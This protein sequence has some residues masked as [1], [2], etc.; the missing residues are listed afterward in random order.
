[1]GSDT[2]GIPSA[3]LLQQGAGGSGE[4]WMI[5]VGSERQDLAAGQADPAIISCGSAYQRSG[6]GRLPV[7]AEEA[8]SS[9]L[10][11]EQ[12]S[13]LRSNSH[14]K[15]LLLSGAFPWPAD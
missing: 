4:G 9:S 1:M 14:W 13:D 3:L 2:L 10:L 7:M 15:F 12:A 6:Q 8:Q 11:W 5:S